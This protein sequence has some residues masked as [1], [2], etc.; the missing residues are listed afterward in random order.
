MAGREHQGDGIGTE[1]R[2]ATLTLGFVGF[3]AD[4][5]LTGAWHDNERSVGVTRKLGYRDQGWRRALR[6]DDHPDRQLAFEMPR[7]HF[8][9]QL[10]RDDIELVGVDPVRDFLQIPA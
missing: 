5:A 1:M 6:D 10:R 8:E 7:E 2:L 9:S 3:G 4:M